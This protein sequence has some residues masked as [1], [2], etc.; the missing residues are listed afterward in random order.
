MRSRSRRATPGSKQRRI[1][2][3]H[4]SPLE[5]AGLE[6]Q[7]YLPV[8]SRQP[9]TLI[10]GEGTW[11]WDAEGRGY[12]DFTGGLGANALGHCPPAVIAAVERQVRTLIHTSNGFYTVPQIEC[13][14]LLMEHS[15]F[16]RVFFANSGAEANE[17][18]I[19]LARRWGA[20]HKHGA[21]EIVCSTTGFHGRTLATMAATGHARFQDGFGPLPPGFRNVPYNDISALDAAIGDRTAALMIEPV[22]GERG[23]YPADP[24]YVEA[25]RR[26]CDERGVLLV[27]DEIQSGIGR[28]GRLWAYERYGVAPDV[29][30]SA[31][32]LGGGLPIGACLV[33]EH[34]SALTRKEH[35][36]T[37]GGNPLVCAAAA[38]VLTE[39][40][41]RD[42]PARAGELG[43]WL[44]DELRAIDPD[45]R[46][47][48]EVRGV[49]LWLAIDLI[50]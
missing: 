22:Q 16:D 33:K 43:A 15:V 32:G 35:G 18:A 9:V 41:G 26:L 23:V 48:L 29:M 34:A 45:K 3:V 13:A 36:S 12:L 8:F 39:V 27:F 46:T 21:F 42:L 31:K 14:K 4:V 19:K 47:I 1:R 6:Q 10:R 44:L 7:L 50:Y 28:T 20:R 37:A 25:A 49:G 5:V 24:A 17:C 11:V 2:G 38:A 40:V 30:T